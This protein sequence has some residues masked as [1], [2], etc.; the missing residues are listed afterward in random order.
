MDSLKILVL[1]GNGFTGKFLCK[2]LQKRKLIFNALLEKI[3][4]LHG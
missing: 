2:E 3:Q 1:G 4:I